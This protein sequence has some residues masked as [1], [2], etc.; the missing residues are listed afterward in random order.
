MVRKS[1]DVTGKSAN[2]IYQELLQLTTKAP[3][4]PVKPSKPPRL[5]EE[6]RLYRD[7]QK[8]R[9]LTE[10]RQK[11]MRLPPEL[12]PYVDCK[13]VKRIVAS[14]EGGGVNRYQ[15]T[16]YDD[17]VYD[18][19]FQ[20]SEDSYKLVLKLPDKY[21]STL[22]ID[23]SENP[24]SLARMQALLDVRSEQFLAE[25]A[26]REASK[27][28]VAVRDVPPKKPLIEDPQLVKQPT[29]L[30]G[31]QFKEPHLSVIIPKTPE[32]KPRAEGP[33]LTRRFNHATRETET[34]Y[35]DTRQEAQAAAYRQVKAEPEIVENPANKL[36]RELIEET[37]PTQL[38]VQRK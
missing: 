21:S 10:A 17:K 16:T 35:R 24:R 5:S 34:A 2:Q 38:V 32:T 22:T 1:D 14:H 7:Y 29:G 28:K 20:A 37:S 4:E 6:D 8:A 36:F 25:R 27:P 33:R 31:I 9:V 26:K 12:Q 3:T 19:R 18:F 13:P 30:A 15:V 23:G 11:G